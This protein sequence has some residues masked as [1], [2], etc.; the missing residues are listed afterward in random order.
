[1]RKIFISM[2][3]SAVGFMQAQSAEQIINA[4]I[5]KTGG[6]LR[7]KKLNTISLKGQLMLG[8]KDKYPLRIFQ[9][10][11]NLARTY[12]TVNGKEITLEGYDGSRG[13]AMNYA[14]GN[15]QPYE[16]YVPEA[17]DNDFLEYG[18]KGFT[19]S[20]AGKAMLNGKPAWKI[21][22]TKNTNR[23]YYYFDTE[24]Y[25]LVREETQGQSVDYSDFRGVQGYIFPFKMS[26]ISKP[27]NTPFTMIFN[28]INTNIALP[29]AT[30]KF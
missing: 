28:Q 29:A 9:S 10:R 16:K 17:F 25:M 23:D 15:I 26:G 14:S 19:A 11:P 18:A 1:M 3:V 2:A 20:V 27:E 13:Y 30:F 4:H 24:N 12:I 7:W 5:E 8:K 6:L 21:E 22:L